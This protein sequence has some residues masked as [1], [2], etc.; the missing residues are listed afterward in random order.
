VTSI[1][2]GAG[3]I[4]AVAAAAAADGANGLSAWERVIQLNPYNDTYWSRLA[5]ARDEAGDRDGA[6]EAYE[7]AIELG[8]GY[9]AESAFNIARCEALSG[10]AEQAIEALARALAMG[11]RDLP[12]IQTDRD[13][14]TL[15]ALPHY[16]AVVGLIDSE[17]VDRDS[18]WAHDLWFLAREVR[19][20]SHH[21]TRGVSLDEFEAQL[22]AMKSRIPA[23]SDGQIHAELTRLVASLGDGHTQFHA[24]EA[25]LASRLALPLRFYLF[26]EG[27]HVV[28]AHPDYQ[29][30]LGARVVG[31]DNRS[32]EH[33]TER[34]KPFLSLDN[35]YGVLEQVPYRLRA[36]PLLHAVGLAARPDQVELTIAAEDGTERTVTV[37]AVE[38]VDPREL[39]Q[40]GAAPAGWGFFPAVA[41]VPPLWLQ[42]TA[43]PYWFCS[44]PEQSAIYFQ[45]NAVIDAEEEHL[46]DFGTRLADAVEADGVNRLVIDMRLNSGGNTFL[47]I[48]LLRY[49]WRS[50]KLRAEGALFVLIGRRTFS[51]GQNFVTLIERFARP[52]F[53]G[54]PTGSSPNFVGESV[55][56]LLPYSGAKVTISDLYHQSSWPMDYRTWIPPHIYLPPTFASFAV[57]RDP[58]LELALAEPAERFRG[59]TRIAPAGR[60]FPRDR[61]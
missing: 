60:W 21:V 40:H 1:D 25:D 58:Q 10:R 8:A 35:E 39:W 19:R 45:F 18:G 50:E 55:T 33:V 24:P 52:I 59:W 16:R 22:S 41:G 17:L 7:K 57:G 49:L 2:Q 34:L 9:P 46:A 54:E 48:P 51:A 23:L 37:A 32:I 5:A 29:A 42:N 36:T 31:I 28:A 4:D 20:K 30:L 47:E 11:Y 27:L 61:P 3:Y 53:I 14:K 38:G 13:L 44:L 6:I 26:E 56:C 43:A 12:R 15:W